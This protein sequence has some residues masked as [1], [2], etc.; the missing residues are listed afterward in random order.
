MSATSAPEAPRC[1][2]RQKEGLPRQAP[3]RSTRDEPVA[4]PVGLVTLPDE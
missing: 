4:G 2:P 3:P 1:E